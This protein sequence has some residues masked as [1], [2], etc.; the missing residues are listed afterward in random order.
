VD[1]DEVFGGFGGRGGEGGDVEV[2]GALMVS[3]R[4]MNACGRVSMNGSG[5]VNYLYIFLDLYAL[6]LIVWSDSMLP[7]Y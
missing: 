2:F 1:G 3:I 4:C 5:R 7:T 6:H